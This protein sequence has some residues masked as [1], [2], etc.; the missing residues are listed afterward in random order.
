MT[1]R[2]LLRRGWS[3]CAIASTLAVSEGTV[4]YHERR[5]LAGA[6]DGRQRQIQLASRYEAPIAQYFRALEGE[7][8][9]NLAA[10]HGWLVSEHEYPGSLRSVERYVRRRYGSPARRARRRVETPPGGQGQADWAEHRGVVVG[11]RE[12]TLWAFQ[13]LLSHSRFGVEVWSES[14]SLLS[15]LE[16]HNRAFERLGGVPATVRVDNE[17]TA[18]VRGAGAWGEIHPVYRRYAESARF[19]VDACA[20]RQPQAKGKVERQIGV[21]RVL[22][23]PRRRPWE[24][25]EELQAER[26]ATRLAETKRRRCPATGSTIWEAFE[27]ERRHLGPLPLLPEPFD[28]IVHRQVGIDCMV[29]FEGRSYSVPFRL[30]GSRVEIRG[31]ARH[32][33]VF[34]HGGQVAR[35]PRHSESRVIVDPSHYSG[36][37]T[38]EVLPPPPLGRMGRRLAEIASLEPHRRPLDLYAALAEVAR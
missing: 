3:R 8:G 22:F 1:I 27:E 16:V 14:K 24:S 37:P 15:W 18:V 12:T 34:D 23:D 21:G 6:E 5:S 25:L 38:A 30:V 17:K 9:W 28:V 4:R 13:L 29:S 19:H 26:D 31:G 10:L 33:L 35:H 20:P 11:R 32:V 36:E 2:E 7:E